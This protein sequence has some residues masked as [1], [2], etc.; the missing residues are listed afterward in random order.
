MRLVQH[1]RVLADEILVLTRVGGAIMRRRYGDGVGV[2]FSQAGARRE[3]VA[4][5]GS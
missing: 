3:L 5:E 1:L 4:C 2:M